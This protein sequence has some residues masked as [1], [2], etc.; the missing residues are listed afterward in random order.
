MKFWKSSVSGPDTDCI[1]SGTG[2]VPEV[3]RTVEVCAIECSCCRLL[4]LLIFVTR[5]FLPRAADLD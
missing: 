3:W 1:L 2:L 4:W 5:V